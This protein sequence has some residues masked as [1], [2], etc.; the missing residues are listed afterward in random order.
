M[1]LVFL[2]GFSAQSKTRYSE[3]LDIGLFWDNRPDVAVVSVSNGGYDVYADGQKI[4]DL[5]DSDA[6]TI[7]AKGDK[8]NIK[9]TLKKLGTFSSLKLIKKQWGSV[10]KVMSISP[11]AESRT[12]DDNLFVSTLW[13][14]LKMVNNVYLEHYVAGVVESEAGP[15]QTYEY[16]KVQAIICRTYALR[17]LNRYSK[18][19]F[20]LCDRVNSQVYKSKSTKNKEIIRAVNDTKGVVIVD[21][22]IKLITAVFHSNSGGQTVNSEDVW[23]QG[24]HYLRS[25]PDSF[26]LGQ[27]HA[28]WTHFMP[29]S[30]WLSYLQKSYKYNIQDSSKIK[31][32][33][34]YDPEVRPTHI[35][36]NGNEI[37]LKQVRNDLK[38]KSTY[39]SLQEKDGY[40]IFKGKGFGH[41][42]G[43]S[44]EG[45]M[46]MSRL[47]YSYKDILHYY[48]DDVH[49]IPVNAIDFFRTN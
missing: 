44:Q 4:Y 47:G 21:S 49:L 31:A 15:N 19:G 39:F 9:S 34:N 13:G 8:I 22:D 1:L 18:E 20:D 16:Y 12:Y 30:D 42:V 38:L 36:L 26:S 25:K 45:A 29:V 35:G 46:N 33:L 17:N 14:R 10:F 5:L 27:P 24:L 32:V 3:V 6:I 48:Y 23:T 2:C 40:V 37:A 41:G 28:E 7:T 11:R 43:L